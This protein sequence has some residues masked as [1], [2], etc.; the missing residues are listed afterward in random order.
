MTGSCTSHIWPYQE[1][2]SEGLIKVPTI[3]H[4]LASKNSSKPLSPSHVLMTRFMISPFLDALPTT[5]PQGRQ[6]WGHGMICIFIT[7]KIP[8]GSA[9]TSVTLWER[10]SQALTCHQLHLKWKAGLAITRAKMPIIFLFLALSQAKNKNSDRLL[11]L[12]I[13][14]LTQI[15]KQKI[16]P[17]TKI[18]WI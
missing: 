15:C 13:T 8:D 16:N 1:P 14:P 12:G 11:C 9:L 17:N 7:L 3:G 18:K 10:K 5:W 2:G 6:S 4:W